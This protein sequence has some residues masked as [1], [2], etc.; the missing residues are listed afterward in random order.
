ME[1]IFS[2]EVIEK[3]ITRA[4]DMI[5]KTEENEIGII[6]IKTGGF[7]LA[8]R[9][10]EQISEKGKKIFLGSLDITFWRDDLSRNP[11]PIVKGTEINFQIDDI[12]IFLID[13][14]IYTGRTV[15]S[16]LCE[17][18]EFGRPKF[19]KLL[20]LVNR[21]GREVPIQPDYF[22][23]QIK[24]DEDK[25]IEVTLMEKGFD[26]ECGITVEKGE[27]IS[28]EKLKNLREKLKSLRKD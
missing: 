8:K 13:D 24:V 27:K 23:F 7:F 10:A 28:N 6:G 5:K 1:I 21:M 2:Q 11:H 18:F 12:P 26:V 3:F 14:V 19:V 17:L 22:A 20:T 16:A 15:R 4:K 9:I 25:L